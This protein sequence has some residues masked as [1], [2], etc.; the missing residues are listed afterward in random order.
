M[1]QPGKFYVV[2]IGKRYVRF[3][4]GIGVVGQHVE[5]AHRF[6]SW[7]DAAEELRALD[8]GAKHIGKPLSIQEIT[9]ANDP[10]GVTPSGHLPWALADDLKSASDD[11]ARAL[12]GERYARYLLDLGKPNSLI[13]SCLGWATHHANPALDRAQCFREAAEIVQRARPDATKEKV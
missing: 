9:V 1:I 12:I 5:H 4:G 11:E 13:A 7:A 8:P 2:L 3:P 10:A 6:V